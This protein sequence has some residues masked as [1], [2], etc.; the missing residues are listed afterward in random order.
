MLRSSR[1]GVKWHMAG[2]WGASQPPAGS[3][4]YVFC[5]D[6]YTV[7]NPH[8]EYPEM[9]RVLAG[10]AVWFAGCALLMATL[11]AFAGDP[12]QRYGCERPIR[13]AWLLNSLVY[14]DGEG[15]DPSLVAELQR[16]TGCSFE[17]ALVKRE[18][19]W[20]RLADGSLD[21]LPSAI[22]N[23]ERLRI[24]YFVPTIYYRNKLI[25]RADLAPK[26]NNFSDV[27]KQPGV[28]LGTIP[29]YWL[30]SYYE[31]GTRMLAGLGRVRAYPN[32]IERFAALRRNE[33]QA[34]ISHEV[35]LEQRVPAEERL[36]F[37]VLDSNP[38][39]SFAAGLMLSRRTFSA[40]QAAEW[41]RVIEGIRLDG[42]L[43][44]LVRTNMPAHLENE[45]LNSGYRYDV[46]KRGGTQ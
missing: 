41:L 8:M 21:M 14:R 26:I 33:V 31:G 4:P 36:G 3:S 18:E 9:G 12:E 5:S 11:P 34:V 46:S 40:A 27:Q 45:F 17:G 20:P 32:E 10:H 29:G 19:V 43:A 37:R 25:V 30:G 44:Q 6:Y 16:R 38:G 42:S 2:M 23:K 13:L 24:S 7:S 35:N 15:F 28:V 22:P 1:I 39:P